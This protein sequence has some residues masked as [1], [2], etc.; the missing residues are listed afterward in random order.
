M[1]TQLLQVLFQLAVAVRAADNHQRRARIAHWIGLRTP[2][3]SFRALPSA[4]L[5]ITFITGA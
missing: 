2:H 4:A 5:Y 3:S 1:F